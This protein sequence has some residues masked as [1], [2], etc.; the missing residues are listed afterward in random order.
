MCAIGGKPGFGAKKKVWAVSVRGNI[1]SHTLSA[2]G[3]GF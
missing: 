3:P 2:Y 1:A